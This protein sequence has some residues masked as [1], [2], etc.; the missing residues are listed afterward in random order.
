MKE[1]VIGLDQSY[2][3][4]GL[5]IAID[6]IPK[7]AESVSFDGADDKSD[8]RSKLSER[9]R[10]IID[11][12]KGKYI[13]TI[14]L[15]AVRL[16]SGSQPHI[17]TSYIFSTCAMIGMFVDI[18][19]E[20]GVD[21]YWVETRSWKKH[22]LGSSKPSGRKLKGVKDPK[23]VDSVLYA[24]SIGFKDKIAY[25]VERGKN[26]GQIRYNDNIADAIC[27]AI[28]GFSKKIRKNLKNF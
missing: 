24:C 7:Y 6:G 28:A 26:K 21:I 16:F 15:E 5:C 3:D 9:L 27:I 17:S 2:T 25:K 23:K 19:N 20:Y 10:L 22:V 12:F 18:A 14:V 4:T 13:I 11:K 8:K 1:M